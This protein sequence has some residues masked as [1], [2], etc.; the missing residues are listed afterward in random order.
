MLPN[1][2]KAKAEEIF[3]DLDRIE[4]EVKRGDCSDAIRV[5]YLQTAMKHLRWLFKNG[6]TYEGTGDFVTAA[7]NKAGLPHPEGAGDKGL[8]AG[9]ADSGEK[10]ESAKRKST[11]TRSR[12]KAKPADG[13]EA[14]EQTAHVAS[15]AVQEG[16]DTDSPSA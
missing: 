9:Q 2:V 12:V 14:Q 13:A 7:R 5:G 3:E 15:E 1:Q 10:A 4:D 11:G 6:V 16:R 8:A